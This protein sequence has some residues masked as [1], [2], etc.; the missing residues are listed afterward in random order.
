M[1]SPRLPLSSGSLQLAREGRRVWRYDSR[2][3]RDVTSRVQ[4]GMGGETARPAQELRLRA[5]IGLLTM[6]TTAAR[7]AGVG[8]VDIDH[9]HARQL[10][11]VGDEGPQLQ[12]GPTVQHS[13][14][15]FANRSLRTLTDALEVFEGDPARSAFRRLHD[16][17]ANAVV[18][19]AAEPLLAAT[20]LADQSLGAFGVL[21][22]ELATQA[23]EASTHLIDVGMLGAGGMVEELTVRRG[24]QCNHAQVYPQVLAGLVRHEFR[25]VYRDRQKEGGAALAVEQ[26]A[27]PAR[28]LQHTFGMHP[29]PEG[30]NHASIQ[31]QEGYPVGCGERADALVVG[32]GPL[33]PKRRLD[34]PVALVGFT[35]LGNGPNRHLRGQSETLP[36]VI[37]DQLLQ[38]DLVRLV[39][40]I[41]HLRYRVAGSIERL[42]RA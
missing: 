1:S 39:L 17:L 40:L 14:L 24:R 6:P 25:H 22:L 35:H 5:T 32:H 19:I 42:Q 33:Q 8:R 41:G 38:L 18:D 13:P 30:H 37:V 29:E 15:A 20:A 2:P 10:R 16:G 36:H 21:L 31:G 34:L 7:L 4:I 23:R 28:T 12:E 9:W 3:A 27:L 26:I 11:L